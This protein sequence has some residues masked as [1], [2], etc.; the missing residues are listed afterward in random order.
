[1]ET[2]KTNIFVYET[3]VCHREFE[4]RVNLIFTLNGLTVVW[5]TLEFKVHGSYGL[6]FRK[7]LA[8]HVDCELLVCWVPTIV[9]ILVWNDF[10]IAFVVGSIPTVNSAGGGA[11]AFVRVMEPS[12]TRLSLP[13]PRPLIGGCPIP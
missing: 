13:S 1:M 3:K 4:V 9:Y 12:W 5:L 10:H 11:A 6:K 8:S 2:K 7:Y